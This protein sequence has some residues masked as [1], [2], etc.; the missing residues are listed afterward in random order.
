MGSAADEAVDRED[1][2]LEVAQTGGRAAASGSLP[3]TVCT[4]S[5]PVVLAGRCSPQVAADQ[6]RVTPG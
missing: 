5:S 2:G 6:G 3:S 4:A 1:P